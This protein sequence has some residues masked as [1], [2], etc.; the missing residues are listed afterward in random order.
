MPLDPLICRSRYV[1]IRLTFSSLE[2]LTEFN[3]KLR[4]S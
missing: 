4:K 3:Y 1:K 2:M